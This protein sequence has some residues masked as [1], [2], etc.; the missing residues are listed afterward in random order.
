MKVKIER[1]EIIDLLKELALIERQEGA[2]SGQAL[3]DAHK[4]L[5][6]FFNT[7]IDIHYDWPLV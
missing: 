5:E 2:T 3:K 7:D 6:H 1:D 4:G